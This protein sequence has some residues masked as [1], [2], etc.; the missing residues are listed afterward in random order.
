M[1]KQ[2]FLFIFFGLLANLTLLAQD[3]D[4]LA[5]AQTADSVKALQI[6]HTAYTVSWNSDLNIPNWVSHCLTRDEVTKK[7][8]SRKNTFRTDPDVRNCPTTKEYTNSGYDR[9]HMAPSADMLWD[10]NVQR[11]CFYMSNMCPQIHNL[12]DGCWG[13]LENRARK[14]AKQYD[15][16]YICAGP[17]VFKPSCV[18]RYIGNNYKILVPRAFF[19]VFIVKVDGTWHGIGFV[20]THEERPYGVDL[21]GYCYTIDEVERLTGIDFFYNLPDDI[22]SKVESSFNY[23]IWK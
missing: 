3:N 18:D 20:F 7:A 8:V 15:S 9:G 2:R 4:R 6:S 10:E 14:L 23:D 19:K 17:V 12:N 1:S 16:L 5:F 13:D 11:E 22:E 21:K